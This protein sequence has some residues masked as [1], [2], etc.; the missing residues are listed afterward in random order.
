MH[1]IALLGA[2]LIG[3][4]Y[5]MSLLGYRGRDEIVVIC[6]VGPG[7]AERFAKEFGIARWTSDMAEA[8]RD[9][10]VDT[11][12]IGLPNFL[13][14]Q[15][16][17]MAVEAGKSVFCTKPLATNAQDALEMLNAVEKAGVFHGYLEDLVYT[18]KTL[19]A[20]DCYRKR[21]TR[22]S[23]LGAFP[24]NTCWPAQRLVLE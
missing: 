12:I 13:H 20:L 4:F 24:R 22:E 17:L 2:G 1:K 3:R 15:A 16:V 19:K 11:V 9:P 8:I 23:S 10:E 21:C 6:A 7:E 18:P 5:T 14:K